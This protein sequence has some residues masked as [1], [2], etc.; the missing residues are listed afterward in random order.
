LRWS[1]KWCDQFSNCLSDWFAYTG[2]A[3]LVLKWAQWAKNQNRMICRWFV[4][5]RARHFSIELELGVG[6]TPFVI[7]QL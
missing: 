5:N 6:S 7:G 4:W 2:K 3:V 1:K